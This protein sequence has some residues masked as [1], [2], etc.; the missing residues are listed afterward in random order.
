MRRGLRSRRPARRSHSMAFLSASLAA[1][2]M[3]FLSASRASARS[4][5]SG[6]RSSHGSSSSPQPACRTCAGRRRTWRREPARLRRT[7]PTAFGAFGLA[8]RAA[9]AGAST[10]SVSTGEG[11]GGGPATSVLLVDLLRSLLHSLGACGDDRLLLLDRQVGDFVGGGHADDAG[12]HGPNQ[13]GAPSLRTLRTRSTEAWLTP[14]NDAALASARPQTFVFVG[15]SG[16][17]YCQRRAVCNA[18][19]IHLA[20]ARADPPR[21]A[22]S[23]NERSTRDQRACERLSK[24]RI[25]SA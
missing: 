5:R 12:F 14:I 4:T 6:V 23:P 21:R 25:R 22:Q 8:G 1:R 11:C 2:R 24:A 18:I 13:F 19:L 16:C 3:A 9:A 15:F 20:I 17:V 7:I 10:I